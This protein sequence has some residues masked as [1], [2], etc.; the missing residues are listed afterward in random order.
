HLIAEDY[1]MLFCHPTE[2]NA[3]G[4]WHV[5]PPRF[6][7]AVGCDL[8]VGRKLYTLL[9]DLGMEDIEAE[10]IAVDTVRVPRE[11]FAA[12]WEAWRDGY[13]DS[14]VEHSGMPR[15]EVERRWREMIECV[16]DP[17]GYALWHVPLWT[18]VKPR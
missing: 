3:D 10:Y 4:F 7:A 18:A 11:T 16:R 9:H 14:I 6:E 13:T 15:E 5:A 1:G 2:L 8:H 17:R 12:I